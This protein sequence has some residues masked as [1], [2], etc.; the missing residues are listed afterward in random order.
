MIKSLNLSLLYSIFKS[1]K[2][3]FLRARQSSTKYFIVLLQFIAAFTWFSFSGMN[4][5]FQTVKQNSSAEMLQGCWHLEYYFQ[6]YFT[7]ASKI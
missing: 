1:S 7:Y 6:S 3:A 2:S 4:Y 5:V